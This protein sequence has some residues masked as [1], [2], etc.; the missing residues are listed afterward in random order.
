MFV[1]PSCAN[2]GPAVHAQE[3]P[4]QMKETK[5]THLHRIDRQKEDGHIA[6][7]SGLP[8]N[9]EDPMALRSGVHF[10]I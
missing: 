8:D 4:E 2:R 6:V 9:R 7:R 3:N 1:D 5:K 10:S